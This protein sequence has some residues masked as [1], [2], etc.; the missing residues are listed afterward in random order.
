MHQRRSIR[1]AAGLDSLVVGD[2]QIR[3]QV[4]SAFLDAMAAAPL[5]PQLIGVFERALRAAR[6]LQLATP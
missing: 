3:A 5:P 1:V 2:G 4:R 6:T